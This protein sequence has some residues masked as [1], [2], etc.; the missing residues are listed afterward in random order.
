M[1]EQALWHFIRE[2]LKGEG[3]HWHR[4]ENLLDRGTPDVDWACWGSEGWI[5]LKEIP[6]WPKR[7]DTIVRIAHFSDDQRIWLQDRGNAGG[8]VHLLM[9]VA[10][11]R[12]YLLFDWWAAATCLGRVSRAEL[13]HVALVCDGPTFPLA[14]LRRALMK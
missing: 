4:V 7:K 13:E 3:G 2:Q 6:E 12:T 5:E 14:A 1:S 11:P 10:R 8:N 9:R